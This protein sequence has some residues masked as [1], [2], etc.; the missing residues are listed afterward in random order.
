MPMW[1]AVAVVAA[2]YVYRSAARGWDFRPAP[3]DF[4]LLGVFALLVVS[5]LLLARSL[6]DGESGDDRGED[7]ISAS[8]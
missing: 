7:G 2:A 4:V 8:S 1:A 6:R 3:F 5:R